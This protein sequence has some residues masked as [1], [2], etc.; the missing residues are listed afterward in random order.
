VLSLVPVFGVLLVRNESVFAVKFQSAD[1]GVQA[2]RNFCYWIAVRMVSRPGLFSLIAVLLSAAWLRLAN[3]QPRYG[4]PTVPD[5]RRRW[6]LQPPRRQADR[7]QSDRRADRIPEGRIALFAETLQTIADV[8]RR[9]DRAAS[10]TSGRWNPAPLARPKGRRRRRRDAEGVCHL[11]PSIWSGASSRPTRTRSWCRAGCLTSIR[12]QILPVVEK[13]DDKLDDIRKKHRAMRSR[14]RGFRDRRPQLGQHDREAQSGFT[15]EFA[16][17]RFHRS[18]VQI[19]GRAVRLHPAGIFRWCCRETV[20]YLLGRGLQFASVVALTSRRA[21]LSARS[22][23]E[24]VALESK[25]GVGSE[26]RRAW[27]VWS[28]GAILT[29]VVLACGWW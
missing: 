17:V 22:L 14:H 23:P 27:T 28:A 5:K 7:R 11:I 10:A 18:G 1:S 25:P 29:T 21:G 19:V 16:L 8:Q 3:L 2:L 26:L 15:I 20:L 13:L 24:P 12:V 9:R 6:R 4:S